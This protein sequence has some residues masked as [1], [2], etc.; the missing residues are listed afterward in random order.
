MF[1]LQIQLDNEI[2]IS[3]QLFEQIQFAIASRHY[4]PGQR[5]PSTRQ[6]AQQLNIHRNTVSR[7]YQLL[8]T[9][10]LVELKQGSGIYVKNPAKQ[11]NYVNQSISETIDN[12]LKEGFNLNEIKEQFTQQIDYRLACLETIIVTTPES[13]LE[14]GELI[15]QELTTVLNREIQLISLEKLATY[16]RKKTLATV[17]TSR[18]FLQQITE[19]LKYIPS[20]LL[21]VDI[22]N[23]HKELAIIKQLPTGIYLGLV[24]LSKGTLDIAEKIIKSVRGEEIIIISAQ[25]KQQEKLNRLVKSSQIIISDRPSSKYLESALAITREELRSFP[26]LIWIENYI[27]QDSLEFL[28]KLFP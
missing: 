12:L 4:T 18:Y 28:Q 11:L 26:R 23:F 22:Y 17:I 7:V 13:D 10:G 6:L 19:I 3:Q 9:Q 21:I 15:C 20:S 25:S 27:S 16:L 24:S 5:L 2:S 8:E 14:A 1:R